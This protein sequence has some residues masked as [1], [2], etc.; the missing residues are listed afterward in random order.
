VGSANYDIVGRH[1]SGLRKPDP[2]I[3][4]IIHSELADADTII[5]I[6]AG[7]GSYEP[8]GKFIVAIDSS[9]TMLAQRVANNAALVRGHAEQLPFQTD[10][11][12]TAL[13]V[14]TIH[15]WD[16]WKAGLREAGRV[17][18]KKIV[19]FTWI[20]MP[21]GFWLFDYF[22]EIEHIDRDLFPSI[23]QLSEVLGPV[24]TVPVPIPAA[25][26]D[27]FL[28]AYWRRPESYL[29]PQIRSAIS[30]FSRLNDIEPGLKK[31]AQDLQTGAWHKRYGHLLDLPSYD[32]GY[33]LVVVNA[34]F[35]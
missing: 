34:P 6:G 35:T 23:E 17:A 15:H 29:N 10:S 9:E 31:L 19:M 33:R 13:A 21:D 14:L 25:C 32:F 4:K 5:N 2:T 28:C 8:A 7:T 27:G 30:T 20:G 11:F 1:Y 18:I 12:D 3:A 24:K 26:T 16:N 22:P